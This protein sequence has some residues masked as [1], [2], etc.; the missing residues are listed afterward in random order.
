MRSGDSAV[1][2][3]GV[4]AMFGGVKIGGVVIVGE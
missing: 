1:L 4:M 3:A 2:S